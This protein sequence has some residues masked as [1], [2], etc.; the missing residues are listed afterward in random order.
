MLL[1]L[2]FFIIYWL[3]RLKK[4]ISSFLLQTCFLWAILKVQLSRS[5]CSVSMYIV[6]VAIYHEKLVK[7]LQIVCSWFG[8]CFSLLLL[9]VIA[10]LT[11]L[12]HSFSIAKYVWWIM[13]H[14]LNGKHIFQNSFS[15]RRRRGQHSEKLAL[16]LYS[17]SGKYN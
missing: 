4:M 14:I 2:S 16:L 15:M 9:L 11:S 6:T 5:P 3:L 12:T 7:Y 8:P 1:V 17:N 13:G 10:L